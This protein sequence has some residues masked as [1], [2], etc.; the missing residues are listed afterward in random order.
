MTRNKIINNKRRYDNLKLI[1]IIISIISLMVLSG[2]DA[3]KNT[4]ISE[5]TTITQTQQTNNEYD[6]NNNKDNG[7]IIIDHTDTDIN[8][9]PECWIEEAKSELKIAYAHTSHGSQ[10]ISGMEAIQEYDRLYSWNSEGKDDALHLEDYYGGYNGAADLSAGE[11]TWYQATKKFLDDK[12]NQD[13]NVIVWSWCSIAGHDIEKN[14]IDNMKKLIAEYGSGSRTHPTPV[15]FV[16]MTGHAEGGGI[17]DA[18]DSRNKLIRE[19]CNG[20]E[21]CV[22]FDFSDIENYDPDGTYY[23]DKRLTDNLDYDCRSPYTSGERDCNWAEEYLKENQNSMNAQISKNVGGC[24][25][26]QALT[27]TLKG[28]AAWHLWARLAGWNGDSDHKCQ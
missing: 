24:A 5:D 13:I 12:N 4:L 2:C 22:L 16:L 3:E 28:Q 11:T 1:I 14:Y 26:S 19:F 27:C 25:H 9:I 23:L 10:I 21:D 17:D 15:R 18:S 6:A 20:L 8:D 7:K